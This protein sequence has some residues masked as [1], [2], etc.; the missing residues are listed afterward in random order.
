[1]LLC[2]RA[3]DLLENVDSNDDCFQVF[4]L[5][6][7][8]THFSHNLR[9][10]SMLRKSEIMIPFSTERF[11]YSAFNII[12]YVNSTM[13]YCYKGDTTKILYSPSSPHK[14]YGCNTRSCYINRSAELSSYTGS[15]IVSIKSSTPFYHL[16]PPPEKHPRSGLLMRSA[17]GRLCG[18]LVG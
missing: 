7:S 14:L 1:M 4:G 11:Y 9:T 5:Q 8:D 13:W 3:I 10:D 18:R 17:R 16:H 2:R 6:I 15:H 12:D